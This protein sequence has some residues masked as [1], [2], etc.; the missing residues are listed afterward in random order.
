MAI[1]FHDA[2]RDWTLRVRGLDFA[3]AE[4]VFAG[5]TFSAED[6]RDDYGEARIITI[7]FLARRMVV[8]VWT[9]RGVDRH[10]LS[11]RKANGREQARFGQRL[12]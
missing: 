4:D 11:M 9:Q 10:V 6:K 8:V 12:G 3:D 5:A 7:G 1:T 2:K